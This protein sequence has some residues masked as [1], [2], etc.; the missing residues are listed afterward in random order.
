[1]LEEEDPIP[2]VTGEVAVTGAIAVKLN[3][4]AN[5]LVSVP[6]SEAT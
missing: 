1:M 5:A 2:M 6:Q 4:P 3:G